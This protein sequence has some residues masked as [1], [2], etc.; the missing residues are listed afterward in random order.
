[1]YKPSLRPPASRCTTL[2]ATRPQNRNPPQ[3]PP[4][5]PKITHRAPNPPPKTPRNP[6]PAPQPL[7]KHPQPALPPQSLPD[8]SYSLAHSRTLTHR[9]HTTSIHPCPP[10]PP[11]YQK[12]KTAVPNCRRQ[13]NVP[14][15]KTNSREGRP[16]LYS[17]RLH[18]VRLSP[19]PR[20]P[21]DTRPH[22]A[23]K[24]PGRP[25]PLPV[26]LAARPA[27]L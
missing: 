27:P 7:T 25:A 22:R 17:I 10:E 8:L 12:L 3:S 4:N 20:Q 5:P 9:S 15:A 11:P 16:C 18:S 24:G 26:K 19:S 23:R 1:M 13:K 21:G 2:P 6:R 14:P